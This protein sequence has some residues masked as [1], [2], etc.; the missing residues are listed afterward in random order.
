ME[1]RP[2]RG[3][4][5]TSHPQLSSHTSF[6]INRSVTLTALFTD[7]ATEQW[8]MT[9][10]TRPAPRELLRCLQED[11]GLSASA[12]PAGWS[13]QFPEDDPVGSQ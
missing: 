9:R 6:K 13:G 10:E 2:A 5:V 12:G 1:A 7:N 8:I 3:V 4:H 11:T